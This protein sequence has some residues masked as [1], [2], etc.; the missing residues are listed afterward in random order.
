MRKDLKRPS[1]GGT[2][3]VPLC[4]DVVREVKI[5]EVDALM[6]TRDVLEV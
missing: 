5:D 2:Q 6:E 1:I 4:D 3:G